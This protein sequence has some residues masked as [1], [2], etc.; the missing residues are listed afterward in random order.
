[1]M[2][3]SIKEL[4]LKSSGILSNIKSDIFKPEKRIAIYGAGFLGQWAV[5]WLLSQ[6]A[7][8][9]AIFDSDTTKSGKRIAGVKVYKQDDILKVQPDFIFITARHAIKSISNK[10]KKLGIDNGSLEAFYIA[11]NFSNF[12]KV[13]DKFLV[14]K[15][16][17]KTLRAVLMAKL[18][19]KKKYCEDVFELGQYFCLPHFAASEKESYVDAGAYVGDSIE[20]FIWVNNGCFSKIYGFEPGPRQFVAL[21]SRINR[22][23]NEWAI[24]LDDI[25]LSQTA[26]SNKTDSI[27]TD[28]NNGQLQSLALSV[29]GEDIVQTISLDEFLMGEKVTFIKA[30]VEGMEMQLLQGAT[31]TIKRYKPKLAICVYH[32]PNDILDLLSYINHIVPEYKFS[33]RH[34]SPQ[35]LETV[36][37]CWV[38]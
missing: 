20:R 36:L 27:C 35:Q 38:E 26:L 17:K 11:N 31:K 23:I 10:L 30:D 4:Q 16:S 25:K 19:G 9:I 15:F 18:S 29:C 6:H 5:Q 37:Y 13:H 8:I 22:L 14:D 2:I 33:L 3:P 21:E 7:N 28:S 1:M 24:N 32:Y 12:I 34:H